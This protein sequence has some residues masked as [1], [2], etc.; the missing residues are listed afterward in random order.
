MQYEPM[1]RYQTRIEAVRRIKQDGWSVERVAYHYGFDRVT[2]YRWLLKWQQGGYKKLGDVSRRPHT[3]YQPTSWELELRIRAM[4][5]EH[6]WC[7]QKITLVL[8]SEGVKIAPVTVYRILCR[9]ELIKPRKK[10]PRRPQQIKRP[11][12][13]W[14]GRLVQ[15]DTKYLSFRRELFQYTFLDAASRFVWAQIN[16]ELTMKTA[17][18][19][20]REFQLPVKA[21]VLQTDNGLEFQEDFQVAAKELGYQTRFN[22]IA[23]PEENG[24]VERFH[25]TVGEE[26]YRRTK[27]RE[28]V[29]LQK[30][31]DD[32]L[33]YYNHER[34]HLALKGRTPNQY[35]VEML[36]MY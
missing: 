29:S 15:V 11:Y 19:T 32:Y 4:R 26:F 1:K 16:P 23:S 22:H 3:L 6:D 21:E 25:R 24:R 9:A 10:Q 2:I 18:K 31:F 34:P 17:A 13:L 33:H 35:M 7:H 27:T 14:P 28:L 5:R 12:P 30:Q 36:Q 8:E 20:L